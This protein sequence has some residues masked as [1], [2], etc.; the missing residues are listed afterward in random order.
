MSL[1]IILKR[2]FSQCIRVFESGIKSSTTTTSNR[3]Q[4]QYGNKNNDNTKRNTNNG[5]RFHNKYNNESRRSYPKT[6]YQQQ[7]QQRKQPYIIDPRKIKFNNGTESARNAIEEIINRIYKLQK[8]YQIQLITNSGLKNYH[9]SEIL[10]NLDLSINGL[11]LIDKST[12][13]T[14]TTT[15]TTTNNG[16]NEL[17]LIKIITV[18]E[19]INQYSTY[20]NNLKQLELIKLGSLKTLKTLD[21]KLKLE[22][23][24][25][26]TKE[27]LIKWSI[28][29]N[30]FKLQKTNEIKKL[31][32]NGNGG[33]NF[34]INMVYN[35]RNINKSID[36]IYKY[37]CKGDEIEEK[38]LIEIELQRRQLLINNLQS[39]LT[40]LNCKWIIEGDINT[41][42]TFNVTPSISQSTTTTT[43][44]EQEQEDY[45]DIEEKKLNRTE[46]KKRKSQQQQ[47][48]QQQQQSKTNTTKKD[49]DEEDLDALYSFKIED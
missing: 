9:L 34:L 42:M 12:S 39:L 44:Q 35:K 49:E 26:T 16:G 3:F 13:T 37:Q 24:K 14:T 38:N 19:M 27:I 15:T 45:N 18:R 30:D 11:Q 29:N 28:N 10:Q 32:G 1:R 48:Q 47:Q 41:K 8:N 40:E 2:D 22:Q 17:P 31:I 6:K 4:A 25:S 33:K 23:K 20:L 46:R 36:T 21:I 5:N 43:T 7:Y